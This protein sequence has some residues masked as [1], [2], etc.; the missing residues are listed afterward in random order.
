MTRRPTLPAVLAGCALA[1]AA[2]GDSLPTGTDSGDQL[3]NAEVQELLVELF[4]FLEN[5]DLD[6]A[7][8]QPRISDPRLF[9]SVAVPI[10][11]SYNATEPCDEGAGTSTVSATITGDVN[12][13]TGEGNVSLDGTIDFNAC[14]VVGEQ[15]T[16]TID[17]DPEL[18]ITADF[19][20]DG[21]DD[22][23]VDIRFGGGIAFTTDD[24]RAGTC[25]A[26]VRVTLTASGTSFNVTSSGSIC[27]VN[28]AG[29]DIEIEGT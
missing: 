20:F 23:T 29:L 17:G 19:E 18:G 25:A 5:I 13:Q 11:D 3:T 1:F 9:L 12:E 6:F 15:A 24:E 26:D 7:G 10:N 8:V 27:G 22:L 2:C 28:A 16:Y 14:R 21:D 4:D